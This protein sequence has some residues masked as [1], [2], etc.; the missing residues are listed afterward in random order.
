MQLRE[1]SQVDD[2]V[3]LVDFDIILGE[4]F[5][6]RF[7]DGGILTIV[8]PWIGD[9]KYYM[10]CCGFFSNIPLVSGDYLSLSELIDEIL[11]N[12]NSIVKIVTLKPDTR[13][14]NG[15]NNK[16]S[17]NELNFLY[18]RSKNGAKIYFSDSLH[19]KFILGEYGVVFGSYNVTFS[20]RY[21]NIEDGN[22]A[23]SSSKV[24]FDKVKRCNDIIEK[25]KLISSNTLKQL[26]H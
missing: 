19:L 9:V 3:M 4:L 24:Y 8:S 1:V 16:F 17:E 6:S 10:G 18:D 23:P 5:N 12:N 7:M 21:K 20:G 13:K 2:N 14:Y 15:I 26:I 25:S 22:F 11:L